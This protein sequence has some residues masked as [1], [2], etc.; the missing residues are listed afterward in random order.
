MSTDVRIAVVFA[1]MTVLF[2]A[3][4]WATTPTGRDDAPTWHKR[5]P[6]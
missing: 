3:G 5:R 2:V 4:V 6:R 1:V